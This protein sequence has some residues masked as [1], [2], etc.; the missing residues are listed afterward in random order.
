MNRNFVLTVTLSYLKQKS[1]VVVK[2]F[3]LFFK[4]VKCQS[5]HSRTL[6]SVF[7]VLLHFSKTRKLWSSKA[8]ITNAFLAAV[9]HNYDHKQRTLK[10][11]NT[12]NG[13]KSAIHKSQTMIIWTC[14][15][16]LLFPKRSA[17]MIDGS[18][19]S[20]RQL[21]FELQN[22]HVYEKSS[23]SFSSWTQG[24]SIRINRFVF[25]STSNLNKL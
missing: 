4:S 19:K 23:N 5:L 6:L 17:K 3:C 21:A 12:Q 22:S 10:Q 7:R 14:W 8:A 2:L 1:L 18:E 20:K 15:S 25:G 9:N 16:K 11:G 13:S 24:S